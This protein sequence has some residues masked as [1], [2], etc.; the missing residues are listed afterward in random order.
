MRRK[1][2]E[3]EKVKRI[4]SLQTRVIAR[5][6]SELHEGKITVD[7]YLKRMRAVEKTEMFFAKVFDT[8]EDFEEYMRKTYPEIAEGQIEHERLHYSH[9][10]KH[11]LNDTKVGVY[12]CFEPIPD[13]PGMVEMF[14]SGITLG[15]LGNNFFGWTAREILEFERE[16]YLLGCSEE[17]ASES[18]KM[19]S[20]IFK[21]FQKPRAR[22]RRR[23]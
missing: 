22:T 21:K 11:G 13:N 2:L 19:I 16:S 20:E 1:Y 8:F 9:S 3:L 17:S 7:E 14:A 10:I 23:S 6:I 18:D 5:C 4:Q 15:Y 12:E